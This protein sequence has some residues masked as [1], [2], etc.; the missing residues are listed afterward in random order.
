MNVKREQGDKTE[1]PDPENPWQ[2]LKDNLVIL[3]NGKRPCRFGSWSR[4]AVV[5][6]MQTLC[7][8]KQKIPNVHN[9]FL[10]ICFHA[11]FFSAES[12]YIHMQCSIL[13]LCKQRPCL[14]SYT[15]NYCLKTVRQS[16]S[17]LFPCPSSHSLCYVSSELCLW[18]PN[19]IIGMKIFSMLKNH[20][21]SV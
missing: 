3:F 2:Y 11:R 7:W 9:P 18:M 13:F 4:S 15:H 20:K 12:E 10:Y 19:G 1:L 14:F 8:W 16:V 5:L 6:N 21:N 17:S